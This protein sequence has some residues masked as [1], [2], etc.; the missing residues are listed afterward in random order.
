[1]A[2]YPEVQKFCQEEILD[3]LGSR[4]PTIDDVSSL[5][6]VMA[7]LMEIQ[8]LAKVAPGSL[9]HILEEDTQ[10]GN[11][12][13]KKG[14]SFVANLTKFLMDPSVFESPNKFNPSRFLDENNKIKR[15]E[16]FVPFGI[17]KRICMGETLAKNEMFIFFVRLIQRL[18][19][20]ETQDK[21]SIH[22]V[23]TGIT[24]IPNAFKVKVKS[25]VF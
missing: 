19:F 25:L 23:T 3:N 14:T 9:T 18:S 4:P 15:Y 21:L 1:M 6:Y 16:Q 10:F 7:T 11:Y 22:N 13:F 8:R 20:E 2:L 17:G 12:H 5:P 24:R